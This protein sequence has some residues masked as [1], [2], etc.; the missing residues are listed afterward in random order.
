MQQQRVCW[1]I[2]GALAGHLILLVVSG[3][4]PALQLL[5][6]ALVVLQVLA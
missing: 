2:F 1:G 5:V 3:V 6:L 4:P